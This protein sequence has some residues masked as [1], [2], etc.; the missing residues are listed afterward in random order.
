MNFSSAL[1]SLL[2]KS[3]TKR[4]LGF[5]EREVDAGPAPTSRDDDGKLFFNNETFASLVISAALARGKFAKHYK[6]SI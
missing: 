4:E 3:L 2:V 6:L 5:G 1:L